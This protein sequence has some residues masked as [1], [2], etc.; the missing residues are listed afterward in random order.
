[1]DQSLSVRR[2]R[3]RRLRLLLLHRH[4]ARHFRLFWLRI[5]LIER[6]SVALPDGGGLHRPAAGRGGVL[7]EAARDVAHKVSE[8][9]ERQHGRLL[10]RRA[11]RRA[12]AVLVARRVVDV[13][14]AF[15]GG[16]RTGRR[17]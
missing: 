9:L 11:R 17:R 16:T 6:S 3:P 1:M 2:L 15:G 14:P 7:D 10:L 12:H 8:D 13:V 4:R 5:R